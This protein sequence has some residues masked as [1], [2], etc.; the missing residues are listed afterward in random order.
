MGTREVTEGMEGME[1]GGG[2]ERADMA[3]CAR[4]H[5]DAMRGKAVRAAARRLLENNHT[6]SFTLGEVVAR[7]RAAAPG[8]LP[9]PEAPEVEYALDML[10]RV[11]MAVSEPDPETGQML[12]AAGDRIISRKHRARRH[13]PFGAQWRADMRG[14]GKDHLIDLLAKHMRRNCGTGGGADEARAENEALRAENEAL[15][16]ENARMRVDMRYQGILAYGWE[17]RLEE[18]KRENEALRERALML[19]EARREWG[20]WLREENAALREAGE[21]LLAA[22]EEYCAERAECDYAGCT[23]CPLRAAADGWR[24][25]LP[26]A[27]AAGRAEG[28]AE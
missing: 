8:I 5:R 12:W 1:A 24:R 3:G 25:R 6:E 23:D 22:V 2:A 13:E 28:R 7:V 4:E 14:Y 17:K 26:E 18:E 27:G 16:A 10:G 19:E 20:G 9:P 11:D 21:A 15:R